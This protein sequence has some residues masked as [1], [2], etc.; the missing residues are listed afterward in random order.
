MVHGEGV[1]QDALQLVGRAVELLV[2]CPCQPPLALV[3]AHQDEQVTGVA[4]PS[5]VGLHV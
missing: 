5:L 1:F 4:D 2:L 3:P